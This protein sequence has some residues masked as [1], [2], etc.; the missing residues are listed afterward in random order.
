M[1]SEKFIGV[2]KPLGK[3]ILPGEQHFSSATHQ[4]PVGTLQIKRSQPMAMPADDGRI[5]H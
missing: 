5:L 3:L 2:R 4:V 1:D